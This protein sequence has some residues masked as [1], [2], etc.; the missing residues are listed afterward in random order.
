MLKL[1][2]TRAEKR[3]HNFMMETQ[4]NKRVSVNK[5]IILK[6]LHKSISLK[7]LPLQHD[8]CQPKLD[9]RNVFPK[10]TFS[11]EIELFK[12]EFSSSLGIPS[13]CYKFHL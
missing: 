13:L 6:Q 10:N 12:K 3:V 8:L 7:F 4:L 9:E 5:R 2:L 1:E 11:A